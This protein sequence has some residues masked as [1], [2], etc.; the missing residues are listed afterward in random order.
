MTFDFFRNN[1]QPSSDEHNSSTS[2]EAQTD[3]NTKYHSNKNRD[4]IVRNTLVSPNNSPHQSN[5]IAHLLA[6][7]R[8][9]LYSLTS[10]L[11]IFLCLFYWATDIFHIFAHPLL[12]AL[13]SNTHMIVTDIMGSFVIP[14][15]VTGM[16]AFIFALPY[17]LYQ[18]WSFIAPGLYP[19]EQ[20]W[21]LPLVISSYLLFLAGMAFAYFIVFPNVFH[22]IV[23]YNAPLKVQMSTDIDKYFSF[24]ITTFLVFGISFEMPIAVIALITLN[25]IHRNTLI[26]ARPYVIV[27]SFIFSAIVTPPDVLSQLVLAIPLCLLF[28]FGLLATR[29]LPSSSSAAQDNNFSNR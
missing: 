3:Q 6:L 1:N 10:I 17:V 18:C 8:C 22:F 20:R 12:A 28:E 25:V 14:M 7:R 13:P 26:H 27:G 16:V 2:I 11:I 4:S 24:A 19:H 5:W 9:I 23:Q 29:W 15:K 21:I